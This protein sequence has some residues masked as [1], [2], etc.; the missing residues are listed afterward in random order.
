M[1]KNKKKKKRTKCPVCG[2]TK[3]LEGKTS[4]GFKCKNCG[5]VNKPEYGKN[6]K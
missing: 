1:K 6:D 5:Y 3:I 2:S 4:K